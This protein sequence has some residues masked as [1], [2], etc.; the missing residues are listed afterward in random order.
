MNKL[1]NLIAYSLA[2]LLTCINWVLSCIC[3]RLTKHISRIFV[4]LFEMMLASLYMLILVEIGVLM[5]M[6]DL[7]NLLIHFMSYLSSWLLACY[8]LWSF[9]RIHS[10]FASLGIM[11]EYSCLNACLYTLWSTLILISCFSR[12]VFEEFIAKGGEIV[13]KV[14]RTLANRVVERRNMV[15]HI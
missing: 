3:E 11:V 1:L 7:L 6:M 2:C 13:H 14:G 12:F 9:V 4:A 5:L 10:C 15:M 8:H